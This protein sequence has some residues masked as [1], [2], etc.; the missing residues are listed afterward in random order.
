MILLAMEMD[1]IYTHKGQ[2]MN[3]NRELN[4]CQ[5]LII[6]LIQSL[7]GKLMCRKRVS[8]RLNLRS[9]ERARPPRSSEEEMPQTLQLVEKDLCIFQ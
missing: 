9:C 8:Q 4:C 5:P 2:A 6:Q 7:N 1:L 3:A